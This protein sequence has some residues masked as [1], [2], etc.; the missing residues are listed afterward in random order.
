[1]ASIYDK[2]SLVLIPSGTKT[3]KVYS[4]KPVSGDGDFTFTRASAATRVNAD[5]NIEKETSNLLTYSNTFSS[6]W[7]AI[8]SSVT[9]GQSGYDGTSDAWLLSKTAGSGRLFIGVSESGVNTYSV[10]VKADA[11]NWVRIMT[12]GSNTRDMYFDLANGAL[13]T[14]TYGGQIDATITSVGGGWYR[15]TISVNE[16]ITLVRIYPAQ[17][18]GFVGGTSGSIYIQDAQLEQGLVARDVITTTTAAVYGGIT[19]NTP[20]LDYTDSSCPALLLEPQRTN[21][22]PDSEY[23]VNWSQTNAT[24]A[25][26]QATSPEGVDN[27]SLS[28]ATGSGAHA[29]YDTLSGSVTSG[30]NYTMS[31]FYKKGTTN[32]LRFEEGYTGIGID[33]DIDAESA[34]PRN[35]ATNANIEDYGSGWY[36]ASFGFT[37]HGSSASQ[38]VVYIKNNNDITSYTASGENIY[39]YGAQ[40]EA[41]SYATS[42]IPTY[43]SSVSRVAETC[44]KTSATD[45]IG[46]NEGSFYAE[47]DFTDTDTDQMYMTLSD[48]TSNNRIHIGYDYTSDFIYCNIRV[49]GSAQG[50]I[51]TPTSPSEGIKKIA[52]AY[53]QDDYVMYI[54]GTQVGSDANANVPTLNRIDIGNYWATG[55]EYPVKQNLLFKTRLT[56]AELADLTT[57]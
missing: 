34:T 21:I 7:G 41:G 39:L 11:L 31:I 37:G 50:L 18:D 38:I 40:I 36:R 46:Q 42:Y 53:A 24:T 23:I 28:T 51:T 44:S 27:A 57:L 9:S 30:A 33:I 48:G 54:N 17:N 12:N 15:C 2:S 14:S 3:G 55:Y 6:G 25:S 13:G 19:D 22:V 16:T 45:L 29:P 52:V 10:Y 47:I 4:Q 56:N 20:R 43:G 32:Y 35:G 1:M 26:N 49:A 5:G 8:G